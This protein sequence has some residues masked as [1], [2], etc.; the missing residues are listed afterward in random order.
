MVWREDEMLA[1]EQSEVLIL[2]ALLE[3]PGQLVSGQK[4]FAAQALGRPWGR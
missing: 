2:R 1:F 3:K 4:P